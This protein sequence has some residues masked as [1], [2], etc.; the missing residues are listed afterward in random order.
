MHFSQDCQWMALKGYWKPKTLSG[1]I[2]QVLILGSWKSQHSMVGS[3]AKPVVTVW[4]LL[5]NADGLMV[6]ALELSST[7]RQWDLYLKVTKNTFFSFK[8]Q[9]LLHEVLWSIVQMLISTQIQLIYTHT[10][11]E[12]GTDWGFCKPW[13][14][15]ALNGSCTKKRWKLCIKRKNALCHCP[16]WICTSNSWQF[17]CGILLPGLSL[18]LF[19]M[20]YKRGCWPF[21]SQGS[22]E[23]V[24]G[25]LHLIESR[26]LHHPHRFSLM[27]VNTSK[28]PK[29]PTLLQNSKPMPLSRAG[30]MTKRGRSMVH[31]RA[32]HRGVR[33]C[34]CTA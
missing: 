4:C 2:P 28:V 7:Q 21:L 30:K 8:K 23:E 27:M 12:S 9:Q 31:Q 26:S 20:D 3:T 24:R 29:F 32:V 18:V 5:A 11:Q 17:W 6:S 15:I 13:T 19:L 25:N 33:H 1:S 14:E 16:L 22:P 10:L 34:P